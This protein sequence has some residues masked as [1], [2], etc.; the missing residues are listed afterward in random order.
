M[1]RKV[2]ITTPGTDPDGFFP[3]GPA[4]VCIEGAPRQC[5]TMPEDFGRNTSATV[6]NLAKDDPALLFSADGGGVSGWQTHFALLRPNPGDVLEDLFLPVIS[7]SNQNQYAF[8]ADPAISDARI[9]VTAEDVW[10]PDEPHY[11]E[12]RFIISVC[13]RTTP[14]S[15]L[16]GF[17]HLED[18]YMT[19]RKYNLD[20]DVKDDILASEK[21]EILARLLRV[22]QANPGLR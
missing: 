3:K 1:G 5:Y 4:S 8:W 18:R 2:T 10:G 19:V 15:S 6:V 13:V 14:P 16:E 11:G 12:H 7:I 17:Y 9:F 22:K 21:P 20:P